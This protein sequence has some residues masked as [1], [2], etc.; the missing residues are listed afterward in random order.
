MDPNSG[1][2]AAV[3]GRLDA[4]RTKPREDVARQLE[5]LAIR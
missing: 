4:I 2:A 5:E 1:S 3:Y